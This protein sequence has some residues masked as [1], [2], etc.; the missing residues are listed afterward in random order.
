MIP[1]DIITHINNYTDNNNLRF[2]DKEINIYIDLSEKSK[3]WYLIYCDY[4]TKNKIKMMRLDYACPNQLDYACPNQLDYA[5]CTNYNWKNENMRIR[6]Y[7][8]KDIFNFCY[9]EGTHLWCTN[10]EIKEIPNEIS[11]LVNLKTIYLNENKIKRIPREIGNL[12]NLKLLALHWNQIE[13]IPGE[14]GNLEN[15]I[16]FWIDNNKIKYVPKEMSKLINLCGLHL[17]NNQIKET[18]EDV[19]GILNLPNLND[20]RI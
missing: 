13:K 6:N 9:S 1:I 16:R 5:K 19:L 3:E 18:V 4:F 14:I 2:L 7:G 17:Y 20:L 12:I 11:N 15:L 10:L 8:N